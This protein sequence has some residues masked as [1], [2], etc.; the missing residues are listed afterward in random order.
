[1]HKNMKRTI[2]H[3]I[4]CIAVALLCS[5]CGNQSGRTLT[6]ATGSIYEC[7][8]VVPNHTLTNEELQAV[9]QANLQERDGSS[10]VED[11]T[12]LYDAVRAVMGANMPCMPQIEAY[13]KTMQ[14]APAQFDNLLKPTRNILWVDIDSMRYSQIKVK[15]QREVWST[16]QAVYHVQAPSA[17]AFLTYWLEH[18]VQVRDWFVNQEMTRQLRFYRAATDKDIRARLKKYF[19]CDML[20]PNDYML[21]MDTTL[22]AVSTFGL[23]EN[24]HVLWVCNNKG[25][26]RRDL[27]VYSY[28]YKDSETFSLP[29]LNAKR[30]EVLAPLISAGVQGSYMGT[31]YK[32]FPPE[33][34]VLSID[35]TYTAEIRGL[36]KMK[37]GEAMGGPY[38][39]HTWLD[40]VNGQ[41]VTAEVFVFAPG[42]KKR[43]PLRQAEAI[44]Y[45]RTQQYDK[46]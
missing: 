27:V 34:R 6:S 20:V 28:P 10:Y 37:G 16:P 31:E 4:L 26:L 35:S 39:S 46:Q 21:L 33:M 3:S 44:L 38:V 43:S 22:E 7:L 12:T 25:P 13:F 1:M 36:W 9:Q 2:I 40:P 19:A 17:E 14:V 5:A 11:I 45:S 18:G 42:Q 32:V 29:Y 41:V 30:D 24:T 23:S 8:V 15:A